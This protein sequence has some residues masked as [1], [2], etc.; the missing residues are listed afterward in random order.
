[1]RKPLQINEKIA[2]KMVEIDRLTIAFYLV[3]TSF[4]TIFLLF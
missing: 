1:M 4:L 3:T 2:K